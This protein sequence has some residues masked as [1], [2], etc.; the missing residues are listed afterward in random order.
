MSWSKT[1]PQGPK[2]ADGLTAYQVA[3]REGFIGTEAQWLES[4]KGAKGDGS[5]TVS[6]VNSI[7]PDALGNVYLPVPSPPDLTPYAKKTELS[8]VTQRNNWDAKETTTGSQAKVNTH[9]NKKTNPHS[10]T[11]AQIGLSNVDDVKQMPI[12]GGTYTGIAKALPN[13]SYTVAQLRNV[14][15]STGDPIG[16]SNGDI[17]IKY[18]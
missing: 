8:T 10:V 7:E 5:G 16:G 3:V 2:G 17:W 9:E 1:V 15:L 12:A 18:A 13:T 6:S 4:L 14:I 11:K